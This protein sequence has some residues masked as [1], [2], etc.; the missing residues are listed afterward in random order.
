[1]KYGFY[2]FIDEAGDEG[3]DLVRPIDKNGASE[4]FILCGVLIQVQ[5][6]K[7][8]I[9][10]LGS[11]RRMLG[12]QPDAVI[13]FRD[14]KPEQQDIVVREIARFKAGL[15]A[16]VSNKRNMR[17]YRNTRC[18]AKHFEIVRGRQRPTK[19]NWFYN[20]MFRY[21]A[22]RASQECARWT[23]RIYGEPRPI[24]IVFSYRKG[25]SYSQT[26]AYLY[27]LKTARHGADYFNNKGQID[28][29]VVHPFGVDCLRPK[30][31][32]G[33]Q[34]ADC[35]ASAIFRSIDEDWFGKVSPEY[36]EALSPLFIRR[37]TAV[38][39]Y[40]YK[41]LPDGFNGP[42]SKNQIGS[43]KAVGYTFANPVK[44]GPSL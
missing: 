10:F 42:L 33:L 26:R 23:H 13:H 14:L 4:Y 9:S 29:S 40:G 12:L 18:E 19:H 35:V 41:L 43:L 7:D 1:M 44:P 6:Y 8:L 28:W 20:N 24:R 27:K 2:L 21:L 17:G 34:F 5:R 32:P 22:E 30:N 25:F 31:E 15:I 37:G 11:L 38:R 36:M 3:V 16:I 39:D